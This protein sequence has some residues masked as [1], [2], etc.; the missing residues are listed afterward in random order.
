MGWPRSVV[1]LLLSAAG[2]VSPGPAGAADDPGV[3]RVEIE[4]GQEATVSGGPI[5]EL[6][7]DDGSLVKIVFNADGVAMLGLRA[8]S[9]QCSFRD[10][11]SMRR[12]LRVIVKD[13]P[14][15]PGPSAPTAPPSGERPASG[16]G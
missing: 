11:A 14:P 7:C 2:L 8:G 6:I 5:R 9:T 12:V 1:V 13:P 3:I 16:G 15:R 10:A 4:V